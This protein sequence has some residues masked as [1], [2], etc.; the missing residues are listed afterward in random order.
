MLISCNTCGRLYPTIGAPY[1]CKCGGYFEI[2]EIPD[3]AAPEASQSGSG[4]WCY[5]HLFGMDSLSSAVSLGEGSTPLVPGEFNGHQVFYKMESLNPTGS[6]K[7]RG[8]AVLVSFLRSRGVTDAVEDSSGNAGASFAAYAARAGIKAHIYVPESTSGPKLNQICMYGAD[9]VRVPGPR[10]EAARAV[11]E[12][13]A[14]GSV[15]ASHAYMPF[16][17]TGIATIVYELVE[18]L[19]C[20]PGTVITPVGHGGLLSGLI[21]GFESLLKAGI[22][23]KIPAFIGVQP[24]NCAP[25]VRAFQSGSFDSAQIVPQPTISEGTAV[26]KPVHGKELLLKLRSYSGTFLSASEADIRK[27]YHMLAEQGIYCEPTSAL[28]LTPLLNDK[29]ELAGPVVTILTG[30]GLKTTFVE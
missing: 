20:A 12:A 21:L 11:L 16:G 27:A 29:I 14:R 3:F 23:Q 6:Y 1:C 19:K 17:L 15:Y 22:L 26:T 18:S 7:D 4:M 2:R 30:S 8:S 13:V 28:A 5:S 24:E 25:I 9:V 10:S